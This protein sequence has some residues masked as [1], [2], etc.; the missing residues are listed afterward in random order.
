MMQSAVQECRATS[1]DLGA[2]RAWAKCSHAGEMAAPAQRRRLRHLSAVVPRS[3]APG[4]RGRCSI[5]D[6]AM[7]TKHEVIR[8]EV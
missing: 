6:A 1:G 8:V 7:A 2:Q 5:D 3:A 4:A